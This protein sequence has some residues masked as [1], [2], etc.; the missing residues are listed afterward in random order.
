VALEAR[1]RAGAGINRA[2]MAGLLDVFLGCEGREKPFL[3]IS[4]GG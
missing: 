4:A 3:R 1:K 2:V